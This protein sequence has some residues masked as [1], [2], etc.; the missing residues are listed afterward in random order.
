MWAKL[1][2]PAMILPPKHA[3]LFREA[4]W[5]LSD[6][7]GWEE[8]GD[9]WGEDM[10]VFD[11]LTQAQKQ[12]V[13]L[14]VTR[15]LLD[16]RAEA[17]PV[18]AVRAAAVDQVY[19]TIE[20]M[21]TF[22]IETD[23]GTHTREM[24]LGAMDEANYWENVNRSLPP[25][26]RPVMR[27]LPTCSDINE[28]ADLLESLRTTVLEDRDFDMDAQ[29]GD[30]APEAAADLKRLMSITPDYFTHVPDDPTAE[31]LRQ[32][33]RERLDLVGSK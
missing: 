32:I 29:F 19:R 26:E 22:D 1:F 28:W 21:I 14:E 23:G 33:R 10:S 25:D 17:P 6:Q 13:L 30:M 27:P 11:R 31:R 4:V 7:I 8:W 3:R 16:E 9:L 18:T 20:D 2:E 15:A 12:S 5:Y 24:L